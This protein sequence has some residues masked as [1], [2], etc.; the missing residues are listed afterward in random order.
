MLQASLRVKMMDVNVDVFPHDLNSL[1][2]LVAGFYHR[3]QIKGSS[4]EGRNVL[5]VTFN[6]ISSHLIK[7]INHASQVIGIKGGNRGNQERAERRTGISACVS[8]RSVI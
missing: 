4:D 6:P 3:M 2:F 5:S 1:L 8:E 7:K